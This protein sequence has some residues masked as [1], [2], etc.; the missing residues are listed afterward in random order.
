MTSAFEFIAVGI[1][2]L[3]VIYVVARFI[4]AAYFK[5]KQQYEKEKHHG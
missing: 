5:S 2:A 4:T 3:I 1:I